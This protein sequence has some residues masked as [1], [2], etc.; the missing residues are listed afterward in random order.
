[1]TTVNVSPSGLR[2]DLTRAEKIAG[3]V[4]GLD[5]PLSA[6]RSVDVVP[7]GLAAARGLRAPGLAIPG[8]RKVGTW[9]GRGSKTFVTVRRGQ[10]ALR[11]ELDG[12][13]FDRVLVGTEKAQ[14]YADR[15]VE[16]GAVTR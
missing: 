13:R 15:L 10:P 7:D 16:L 9:R 2:I 14:E 4:R 11:V 6:V 12:A 8:R 1:M 5:V 3:L